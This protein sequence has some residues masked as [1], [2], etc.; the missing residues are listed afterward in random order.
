MYKTWSQQ[1]TLYIWVAIVR[2]VW[3]GYRMNGPRLEQEHCPLRGALG[4]GMRQGWGLERAELGENSQMVVSDP[5]LPASK[6]K[7][8]TRQKGR[9]S[10]S[11]SCFIYRG[12]LE[13]SR[14]RVVV[15]LLRRGQTWCL[16]VPWEESRWVHRILHGCFSSLRGGS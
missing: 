6:P 7:S 12:K 5:Y 3:L 10:A 9:S 8:Q 14:C 15:Q 16:A 4:K 1:R 2:S 11:L 13:H